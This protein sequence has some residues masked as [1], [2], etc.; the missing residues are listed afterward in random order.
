[1]LDLFFILAFY[2]LALAYLYSMMLLCIQPQQMHL[3]VHGFK[4]P[5]FGRS[6][7]F[8]DASCEAD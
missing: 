2:I 6:G 5:S 1:M 8:Y 3:G 7:Q 4:F